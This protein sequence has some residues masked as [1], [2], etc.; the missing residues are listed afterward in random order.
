MVQPLS[1]ASKPGDRFL[2]FSSCFAQGKPAETPVAGISLGPAGSLNPFRREGRRMRR[3]FFRQMDFPV[4][5]TV[6]CR[7][8]H[9]RRVIKAGI[10]LFRGLRAD[11]IITRRRGILLTVT[12]ADCM[13][14]FLFDPENLALGLC[15][16]GWKGT[17][18]AA[19]ALE[20]MEAAFG[21]RPERVTALLGPSIGG[22]C[23]RVDA[24]R[25]EDFAR[26]WGESSTI[27]RKDG[28]YL[29]LK[30]A[31]TRLLENRGVGRILTAD[32]CTVC[33]P[34]FGSFRRE[35]PG[36]YTRMAAF[37]GFSR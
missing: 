37:F 17:G 31:N 15:H 20:Q 2:D 16:S 5:R 7:Q 12:A 18:I 23:Y 35:G 9:T 32:S 13:P 4:S 26:E 10:P 22:C 36:N 3:E 14:V 21:T 24:R 29:D 25:A 6:H 8:L 33:D 30:E 1:F 34:R 28:W 11:G 27:R 19:R